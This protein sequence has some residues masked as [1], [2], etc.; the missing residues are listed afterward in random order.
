MKM[1]LYGSLLEFAYFFS[2]LPWLAL[3]LI[4]SGNPYP[5]TGL[6]SVLLEADRH[7]QVIGLQVGR[8]IYF[9]KNKDLRIYFRYIHK[10]TSIKCMF[11]PLSSL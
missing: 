2:L 8:D 5:Q 11:V 1:F 6:W 7:P 4:H 10:I 9:F 3:S